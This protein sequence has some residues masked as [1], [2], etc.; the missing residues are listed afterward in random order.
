LLGSS[1]AAV[2]EPRLQHALL[3]AVAHS[4]TLGDAIIRMVRLGPA[5][6]MSTS[7]Q[8]QVGADETVVRESHAYGAALHVQAVI[9]R[10][11]FFGRIGRRLTGERLHAKELRL[12]HP[13]PI[14]VDRLGAGFVGKL[15]FGAE[16]D[17]VVIGTSVLNMRLLGS[18]AERCQ[19]HESE[20][21]SQ[22]VRSREVRTFVGT[23]LALLESGVGNESVEELADHLR[24]TPRTVARKLAA[25]GVTYL[26]LRDAVRER[27]AKE[28]LRSTDHPATDIG[29]RL[30]FSDGTAFTRAFK[31]WTGLTPS[32]YREAG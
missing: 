28:Y 2:L 14:A 23:V 31:R 32:A 6:G 1:V 25:E 4:E 15:V 24:L 7:T 19:R 10:F 8:L 27:R 20:A 12:R 21:L 11:S 18:D 9:C 13:E 3:G 30:G 16:F 22:L 17:E 26:R 29:L 5:T